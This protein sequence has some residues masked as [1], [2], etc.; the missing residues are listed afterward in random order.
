[1]SSTSSFSE[2][3]I[4]VGKEY[5]W[6][7]PWCPIYISPDD[8]HHNIMCARRTSACTQDVATF[9][10]MEMSLTTHHIYFFDLACRA[11]SFV[12]G[13]VR[14]AAQGWEPATFWW[15]EQHWN[16]SDAAICPVKKLTN[17][18]IIPWPEIDLIVKSTS[19]GHVH[20]SS[21]ELSPSIPIQ[22]EEDQPMC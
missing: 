5:N 10:A 19:H 3:T 14:N 21:S 8:V 6:K 22:N 4:T 11:S 20:L 2:W 13:V 15:D 7:S 9:E 18:C 16:W 12:S 17:D 1:M